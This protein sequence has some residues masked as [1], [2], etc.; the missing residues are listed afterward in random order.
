[1][2]D[3]PKIWTPTVRTVL[4]VAAFVFHGGTFY[5]QVSALSEDLAEIRQDL[6]ELRAVSTSQALVERDLDELRRRVDKLEEE[7]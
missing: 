5:A 4:V 1:M 7:L 6:K 2:S 3:E